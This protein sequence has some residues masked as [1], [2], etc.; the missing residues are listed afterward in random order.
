M[1]QFADILNNGIFCHI[2]CNSHF[3]IR[4][5]H[6]LSVQRFQFSYNTAH[7]HK[8]TSFEVLLSYTAETIIFVA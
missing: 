8:I 7:F 1:Y 2:I 3:E 4:L 6:F 5:E